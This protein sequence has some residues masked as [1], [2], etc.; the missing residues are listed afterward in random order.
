[1]N[2]P[3]NGRLVKE[4]TPHDELESILAGVPAPSQSL[5]SATSAGSSSVSARVE[6]LLV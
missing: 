2:T 4:D 5:N 1:M 3:T 6:L